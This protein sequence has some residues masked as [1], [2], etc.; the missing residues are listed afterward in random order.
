MSLVHLICGYKGGTGKDDLH[1]FLK[2]GGD[3]LSRKY[4]IFFRGSP[5]APPSHSSYTSP[6][7][8]D[9]FLRRT[10]LSFASPLKEI[11]HRNL[12]LPEEKGI[13]PLLKNIHIPWIGCSLREMYIMTARREKMINGD[14]YFANLLAKEVVDTSSDHI[15]DIT[16]FR[17]PE[18][19]EVMKMKKFNVV[20]TRV[21]RSSVKVP[22]IN[23]VT[24]R[25]LDNFTTDYLV[26]PE[27][28]DIGE[29]LRMFPQYEGFIRVGRLGMH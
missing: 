23:D 20:T 26:I 29:A 16:D 13:N 7:P 6:S 21:F 15:Y 25:S 27:E 19:L 11:V 9:H 12:D 22:D 4:L 24:E 17:F 10:R 2:N 5:S 28:E 8:W 14:D 18:E 3:K 1:L